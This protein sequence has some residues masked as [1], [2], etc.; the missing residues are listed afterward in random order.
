MR[1]VV[2]VRICHTEPQEGDMLS[3][4]PAQDC[5]EK[6]F[7]LHQ[8]HV[9]VVYIY[10]L[11]IG[12]KFDSDGS[13]LTCRRKNLISFLTR[14]CRSSDTLSEQVHLSNY[15][16]SVCLKSIK[17]YI[18]AKSMHVKHTETWNTGDVF[19]TTNVNQTTVL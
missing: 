8:L 15:S 19:S 14:R 3:P 5:R 9:I 12:A 11:M 7:Q 16:I 4:V 10:H 18:L 1:F 17:L 6:K 13:H 2:I